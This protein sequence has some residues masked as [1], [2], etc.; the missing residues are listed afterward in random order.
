MEIIT[1]E[2]ERYLGELLP[3]RDA[4][5]VEMEK[6]AEERNFPIVGPQVGRFCFQ[7]VKM[8]NATRIFELGS[9]F[10]YS[11]YWMAQ[12][13]SDGGKIICTEKSSDN[14]KLAHE[15]LNRG[16]LSNKVE[17]RR[18]NALDILQ[19]FD[20][21]FD[22]ILN[23]INKEDYPRSLDLTIPRL[24]TGGLLVTDNLLWHGRVVEPNPIPG[25]RGVLEYNRIIF[26]H[27]QLFTTLIPLRDGVGLSMKIT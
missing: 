25:T 19:Q 1:S 26:N 2:I 21:P 23:D 4:V 27:P 18:G 11:A 14:I 17:F 8:I 20:G 15:F 10:G 22:I 6:L 7:L 12:A 24:R 13:L 5:L 9:G 16:G 3:A